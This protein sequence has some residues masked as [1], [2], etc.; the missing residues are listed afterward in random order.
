MPTD[1][2]ERVLAVRN[3]RVVG[4]S[5][6]GGPVTIELAGNAESFE[7][8]RSAYALSPGNSGEAQAWHF[9]P[10]G[11]CLATAHTDRL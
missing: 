8:L 6:P 11:A 4:F 2:P 3:K 5:T 7:C 10:S 9:G 1:Q